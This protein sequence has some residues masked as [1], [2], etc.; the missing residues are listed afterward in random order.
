MQALQD[1]LVRGAEEIGVTLTAQNVQ[2]YLYYIKELKRWNRK[3]NLTALKDDLEIGVKHILDSL[4][5][6][7]YL[8]GVKKV[9]DIGTGAGF[10]GVPLKILSSSIELVL[11][12]SSQKKVFFLRH[13][14]RGLRLEGVEV[15]HGRAQQREIMGK[16]DRGFDL[17]LSRALADL[18]TFLRLALPHTKEGGFILGMRGNRGVEELQVVDWE[19]LDLRLMEMKKLT[20]PFLRQ[21]RVLLLFQLAENPTGRGMG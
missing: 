3:V 15:I 5:A 13:I 6:A 7:P 16:Y 1:I 8:Q 19:A 18:P 20:L 21:S 12:E 2:S 11:L 9:L 14:V 4:T 10:P 17:V